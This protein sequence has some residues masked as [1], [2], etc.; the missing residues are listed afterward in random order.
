MSVA[1]CLENVKSWV[2]AADRTKERTLLVI[3][4]LRQS[5][6]LGMLASQVTGTARWWPQR[7]HLKGCSSGPSPPGAG[8]AASHQ[9]QV[10]NI[11]LQG[12]HGDK[13]LEDLIPLSDR[14]QPSV[15]RALREESCPGEG[16]SRGSHWDHHYAGEDL[17]CPREI[18]EPRTTQIWAPQQAGAHLSPL[19]N[20]ALP[21]PSQSME[22]PPACAAQPQATPAEPSSCSRDE[23]FSL[24]SGRLLPG[25][26]QL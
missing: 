12:R 26:I 1:S 10:T 2:F 5:K 17:S 8:P 19:L 22:K 13:E 7:S 21:W 23:F 9:Q 3:I 24:W 6:H 18:A 14:T 25:L 4:V 15:P 20:Q 11:A 16:V